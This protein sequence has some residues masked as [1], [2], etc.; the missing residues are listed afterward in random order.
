MHMLYKVQPSEPWPVMTL[1]V[2]WN[3]IT[4]LSLQGKLSLDSGQCAA[5]PAAAAMVYKTF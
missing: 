4:G 2:N 1:I 5:L 3:H